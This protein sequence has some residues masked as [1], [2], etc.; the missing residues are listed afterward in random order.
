MKRMC[1]VVVED[2]ENNSILM[3]KNKRGLNQGYYNLPGGKI[4]LNETIEDGTIRECIEETGITPINLKTIGKIEF[5]PLNSVAYIYYADQFKGQLVE[6][7][8]DENSSFWISK[9]N[10]PYDLMRPSDSM[11]IK[12]VI[13]NK[14]INKRL[15][16]NEDFSIKKIE[17]INDNI[18][19]YKKKYQQ[20]L[21][22]KNKYLQSKKNKLR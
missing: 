5:Q 21:I 4:E 14:S 16:F 7:N 19:K 2:K 8:G 12:D 17:D 1:L 20:H 6:N 11:W 3:V 10:I 15:T 18:E 9:D 22:L 13:N